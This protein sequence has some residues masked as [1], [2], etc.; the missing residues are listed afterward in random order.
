M[1]FN[2][3]VLAVVTLLAGAVYAQESSA[4]SDSQRLQGV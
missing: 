4:K 2:G 3:L 1:R